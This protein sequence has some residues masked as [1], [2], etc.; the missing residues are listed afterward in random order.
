V[1]LCV[2]GVSVA[3]DRAELARVLG[4]DDALERARATAREHLDLLRRVCPRQLRTGDAERMS[5]E[6][7][8]GR[9]DGPGDP[10]RYLAAADEWARFGRR[11]A[12]AWACWRAAEAAV[13]LGRD[14]LA[15]DA[16]ARA[17]AAPVE[18]PPSAP[19]VMAIEGL[20]ERAR[21][22][23][24]P[25]A[26][27]TEEPPVD[28]GLTAREREVLALVGRGRSN[29]EIGAALF[30]SPKTASVHVSNIMRK[31]GVRRRVE[32]AGV[33]YRLGLIAADP[34]ADQA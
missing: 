10:Q 26:G 12:E 34:V 7:E 25:A 21:L 6:A 9:I 18:L 27:P 11:W 32:A 5:A 8:F 24:L 29:S 14:D 33:A 19:L 30:I 3:A 2:L 4:D 31:L 20:A 13:A 15:R 22:G 1:R 23:P 17:R 16:L 28:L